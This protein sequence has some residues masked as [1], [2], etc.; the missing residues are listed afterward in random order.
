MFL[1]ASAECRT[2]GVVE[3]AA[4]HFFGI[5]VAQILKAQ[6]PDV[7]PVRHGAHFDEDLDV[8]RVVAQNPSHLPSDVGTSPQGREQ[9]AGELARDAIYAPLAAFVV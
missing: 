4:H 8:S 9:G 5:A 1:V 2:R 7:V 3:E 6:S